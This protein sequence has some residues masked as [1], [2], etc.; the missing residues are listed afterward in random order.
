MEQP[1]QSRRTREERDE[2]YRSIVR[3]YTMMSD[4]FMRNVLKEQN[5]SFR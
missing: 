4:T 5:I 3:N 1:E 2:Y